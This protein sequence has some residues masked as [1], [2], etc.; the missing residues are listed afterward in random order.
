LAV[1]VVGIPLHPSPY[2]SSRDSSN[3]YLQTELS[4]KSRPDAFTIRPKNPRFKKLPK[5][6]YRIENYL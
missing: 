5:N 4:A 2:W 3:K 1:A 6:F